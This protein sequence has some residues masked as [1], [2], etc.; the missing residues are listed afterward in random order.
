VLYIG[1][2]EINRFAGQAGCGFPA[3]MGQH[4]RGKSAA[5]VHTVTYAIWTIKPGKSYVTDNFLQKSFSIRYDQKYMAKR[6]QWIA[7]LIMEKSPFYRMGIR[8]V[9]KWNLNADLMDAFFSFG[10]KLLIK[11]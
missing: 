6:D 8:K 9:C 3:R 1:R 4:D 10:K 7:Q 5:L 2:L 11:N